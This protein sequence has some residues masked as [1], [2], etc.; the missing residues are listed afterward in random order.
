M[1]DAQK[2]QKK[3]DVEP[4]LIKTNFDPDSVEPNY[5]YADTLKN[6]LLHKPVTNIALEG[7]F[8]TGKSSVLFTLLKDRRIKEKKPKLISSLTLKD[9]NEPKK[10]GKK[11][12]EDVSNM[13]TSISAN[14]SSIIIAE[15]KPE[16]NKDFVITLQSEI[17]RQLFYGEK[18][19]K[20]K[21]SPYG[22]MERSYFAAP[23]AITVITCLGWLVNILKLAKDDN[24][25]KYYFLNNCW[26]L[27]AI[28]ALFILVFGACVFVI[29]RKI[30]TLISKSGIKHISLK[31][32]NL[33]LNDNEPDFKQLIDFIIEYFRITKRKIVVFEDLDRYK[34]PKIFEELN[35][36][37]QTINH[38][39]YFKKDK[40]KIKFLYLTSGKIFDNSSDKNK[41]FDAIIPMIP[42]MSAS[43]AEYLFEQELKSRNIECAAAV[44]VIGAISDLVADMRVLK[45]IANRFALCWKVFELKEANDED[46]KN[47]ASLSA[48][49][50]LCPEEFEKL[51]RNDS[52]LDSIRIAGVTRK[53]EMISEKER[54]YSVFSLVS[55]NTEKIQQKIMD[56][57]CES[58]SKIRGVS[59]GDAQ[60]ALVTADL[61][62]AILDN[63]NLAMKIEYLD[64]SN[65]HRE[66]T[67]RNNEVRRVVGE[68]IPI[69]IDRKQALD[70]IKHETLK[71]RNK[72]TLQLGLERKKIVEVS[73]KAIKRI[74]ESEFINES[75]MAF[76]SKSDYMPARDSVTDFLVNAIRK[77][78][79]RYR[80]AYPVSDMSEEIVAKMRESDFL[81]VGILNYDIFDQLFRSR[82]MKTKIEN[83]ARLASIHEKEFID[84]CLS[85]L[86][87]G[88]QLAP[89]N[90]E[91]NY[92]IRLFE[93]VEKI[94][95]SLAVKI[96]EAMRSRDEYFSCSM[97]G[98]ILASKEFSDEEVK[99]CASI[100]NFVDYIKTGMGVLATNNTI[101]CHLSSGAR[102]ER[103]SLYDQDSDQLKNNID[104]IEI[105]LNILNILEMQTWLLNGYLRSHD[106]SFGEVDDILKFGKI[107]RGTVEIIVEKLN[108]LKGDR[109]NDVL[110]KLYEKAI[111]LGV[112]IIPQ[113]ACLIV[114]GLDEEAIE[115]YIVNYCAKK[116]DV[117]DVLRASRKT[118]FSKIILSGQTIKVK[119]TEIGKK[120]A[121]K[122]Q[123]LGL[124]KLVEKKSDEYLGLEE[125]E[126]KIL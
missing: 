56:R 8:A 102:I 27:I 52:V 65:V 84:F 23:L 53:S 45:S 123:K 112:K 28:S 107:D 125:I 4:D 15:T 29:A 33:D 122:L 41:V 20:I 1:A 3:K 40:N 37:N 60:R 126:L 59:V 124:V 21:N 83:I 86:E 73:R 24:L 30:I 75:Y 42:F 31:D 6:F 64:I 99:I 81:S 25:I 54:D 14:N 69:A 97:L 95:F 13:P 90:S 50:E 22:R 72:N 92:S 18:A 36:L 71:I 104:S 47:C 93:G 114:S 106:I 82:I 61:V 110:K 120:F 63:I 7:D 9:E 78:D 103:L 51:T 74:I 34:N 12:R 32:I 43:N 88:I 49:A 94:N 113:K 67:I 19:N 2:S 58:E 66:K 57:I 115:D 17:V 117:I 119:N 85:Y 46:C 79:K 116:K 55:K 5:P 10:K 105:L 76:V 44:E 35:N 11:T 108:V 111:R 48:I 101:R 77:R 109:Y 70:I 91:A 38:S 26:L 100:S 87:R 16:D 62:V 89:M 98:L 39:D 96:T 68:I 80:Y 118:E 121:S